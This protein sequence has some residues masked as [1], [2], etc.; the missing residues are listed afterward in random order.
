MTIEKMAEINETAEEIKSLNEA[1]CLIEVEA[2]MSGARQ[3]AHRGSFAK[4]SPDAAQAIHNIK[5]ADLH[6][7]LTAAE[8]K[9]A[10]L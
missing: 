4:L 8:Q 2:K 1:I 6:K 5:L 3:Q 10:A 7:Q 9:F